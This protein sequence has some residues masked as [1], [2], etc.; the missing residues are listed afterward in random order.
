MLPNNP[1]H[2]MLDTR[3][4]LIETLRRILPIVFFWGALAVPTVLGQQ[5]TY[6]TS[7]SDTWFV[8]DGQPYTDADGN[9]VITDSPL[10]E[11]YVNGYGAIDGNT[12]SYSHYYDPLTVTIHRPDG[13][14][15]ISSSSG[16]GYVRNDVS[17]DFTDPGS[18]YTTSIASSYCP[19]CSCYHPVGGAGSAASAGMSFSTWQMFE[20]HSPEHATY[21]VINPCDVNCIP[22]SGVYVFVGTRL[23]PF[24]VMGE[25]WVTIAGYPVCLGLV[26][27]YKEVPFSVPCYD[28]T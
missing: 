1:D 24:F 7:Y 2:V 3:P 17:L 19:G 16:S 8:G 18:Y 23:P 22:D 14:T 6:G 12:A 27:F 10:P 28:A 13:S 4:V 25:P 11:I 5:M 15:S 21:K 9:R 26:K 20:Q